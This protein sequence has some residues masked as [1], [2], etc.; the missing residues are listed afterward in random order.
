[1][2]HRGNILSLYDN[3]L[4]QSAYKQSGGEQ[5]GGEQSGGKPIS[6]S[7]NS[8]NSSTIDSY[9]PSDMSLSDQSSVAK[10]M[11]ANRELKRDLD[12]AQDELKKV[13]KELEKA[14]AMLTKYG[15]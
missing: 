14:N 9:S 6:E 13:K 15:K 4:E 11:K 5:S 2:A 12:I 1:M 10:L 7:N 3:I 8:K